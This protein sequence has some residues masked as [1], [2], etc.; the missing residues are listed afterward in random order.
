MVFYLLEMFGI[1]KCDHF[2]YKKINPYWGGFKGLKTE[3]IGNRNQFVLQ[4]SF[5]GYTPNVQ[6]AP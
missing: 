2:V 1:Y 3:S 4:L 6:K 5:L